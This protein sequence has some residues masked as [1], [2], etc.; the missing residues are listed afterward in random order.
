L[1]T[2]Q[3]YAGTI[4]GKRGETDKEE[5]FYDLYGR[6]RSMEY[7]GAIKLRQAKQEA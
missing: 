1:L 2:I 7:L 5:A 6:I 4:T 3:T